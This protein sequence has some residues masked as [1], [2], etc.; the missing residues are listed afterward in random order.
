MATEDG[1]PVCNALWSSMATWFI[2]S[3]ALTMTKS[4]EERI[5]PLLGIA[6]SAVKYGYSDPLSR[7]PRTRVEHLEQ[8]QPNAEAEH[9]YEREH[10]AQSTKR[11]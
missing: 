1:V 8:T 11:E 3:Q 6:Q 5:G 10:K 4:H 2:R 7:G 9:R